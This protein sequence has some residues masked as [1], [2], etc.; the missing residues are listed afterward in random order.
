MINVKAQRKGGEEKGKG[1]VGEAREGAPCSSFASTH[2]TITIKNI[3]KMQKNIQKEQNDFQNPTRKTPPPS[4]PT[5]KPQEPE[6]CPPIPP[7]IL[8]LLA[9]EGRQGGGH[10]LLSCS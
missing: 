1:K 6:G 10:P 8:C 4:T 5:N 9:G 7:V 3:T 2:Q